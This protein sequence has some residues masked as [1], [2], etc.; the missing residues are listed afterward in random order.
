[1]TLAS[2]DMKLIYVCM[3]CRAEGAEIYTFES[4]AEGIA[5]LSDNRTHS[6]SWRSV[7]NPALVN[8]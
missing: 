3:E 1:M 4:D 6:L 8:E 5:H 7:V 2:A